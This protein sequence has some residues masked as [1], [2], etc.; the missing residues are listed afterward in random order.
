MITS[1][2]CLTRT[3]NWR[4]GRGREGR[5]G[6]REGREGG[7]GGREGGRG[8]RGGREGGE[9]GEGRGRGGEGE[10]RE[11]GEGG[12]EGGGRGGR[13]Q[14]DECS[15][16]IIMYIAYFQ[17]GSISRSPP[18]SRSG[19]TWS[20][21]WRRGREGGEEGREGGKHT[22]IMRSIGVVVLFVAS[23]RWLTGGEGGRES[24][25]ESHCTYRHSIHMVL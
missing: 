19:L 25:E 22:S 11:G 15:F 7:K 17:N 21:D 2:S 18:D 4:I 12:R 20:A 10:G 5:E 24:V 14:K 8:G 13:K 9:G 3:A 6:G 1:R 16:Y 23:P